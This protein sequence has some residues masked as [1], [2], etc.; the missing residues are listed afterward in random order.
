MLTCLAELPPDWVSENVVVRIRPDPATGNSYENGAN[1]SDMAVVEELLNPRQARV[2]TEVQREVLEIGVEFLEPVSPNKREHAKILAGPF[3]GQV[4][5]LEGIN[6]LQGVV[7]IQN[8]FHMV[9][10]VLLAKYA[11]E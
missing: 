2:R 3:R 6:E 8:D 5:S 11:R 1:D 7:K 9:D 4:G 10:M